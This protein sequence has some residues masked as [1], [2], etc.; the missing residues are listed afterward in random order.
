MCKGGCCCPFI[1][2]N[3]STMLKPVKCVLLFYTCNQQIL[4][5]TQIVK[6]SKRTV[7]FLSYLCTVCMFKLIIDNSAP[8]TWQCMLMWCKIGD[9]Y[10]ELRLGAVAVCRRRSEW[11]GD[12]ETVISGGIYTAVKLHEHLDVWFNWCI[13]MSLIILV[14][15]RGA[16]I[17]HSYTDKFRFSSWVSSYTYLQNFGCG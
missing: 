9:T 10:P 3:D 11:L 14:C 17:Q 16:R 15:N 6:C 5:T 4:V 8:C 1:L 12:T 2:T 13:Y 7:R